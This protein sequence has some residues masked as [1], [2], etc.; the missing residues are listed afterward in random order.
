MTETLNSPIINW[1]FAESLPQFRAMEDA[2]IRAQTTASL[3]AGRIQLIAELG[4]ELGSR[5]ATALEEPSEAVKTDRLATEAAGLIWLAEKAQAELAA[6]SAVEAF[7]VLTKAQRIALMATVGGETYTATVGSY[8][9]KVTDGLLRE[10]NQPPSAVFSDW[11]FQS[12]D[13]GSD[14]AVQGW[15]PSRLVTAEDINKAKKN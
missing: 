8:G 9:A 4:A 6:A 7:A 13:G 10:P 12:G 14:R 11:V 15:A 5:A 2:L 1:D 3:G